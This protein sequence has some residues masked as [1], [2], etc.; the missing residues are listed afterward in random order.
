MAEYIAGFKT[1]QDVRLTL[2]AMEK[3][4]WKWLSWKKPLEFN[5]WKNLSWN[6]SNLSISYEYSFWWS[7]YPKEDTIN[8]RDAIR[9]L[10]GE[11]VSNPSTPSS[12]YATFDDVLKSHGKK[13]SATID[14][15]YVSWVIDVW[16]NDNVTFYFNSSKA[17]WRTST[18]EWYSKWWSI[19]KWN[20]PNDTLIESL[21]P[22]VPVT[23]K[24]LDDAVERL[25]TVDH[26]DPTTG[27]K[28][29]EPAVIRL[30]TATSTLY[31][32]WPSTR[33]DKQ[34]IQWLDPSQVFIDG[35][36]ADAPK[37]TL[38]WFNS[39]TPYRIG[40]WP[41]VYPEWTAIKNKWRYDAMLDLI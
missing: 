18:M 22:D 12:G 11:S 19:W 29:P 38:P 21:I 37:K 16:L 4:W 40:T 17:W 33:I 20:L 26:T 36:V 15:E 7:N 24:L 39:P 3:K 25:T 9:E 8:F 2:E 14:W 27:I 31:G 32:D 35:A 41:I 23:A 13:F 6:Y 30:G 34:S 1:E 5:W 10:W 28:S